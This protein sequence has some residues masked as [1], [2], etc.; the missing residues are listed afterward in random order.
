MV[1]V[2]WAGYIGTLRTYFTNKNKNLGCGR[3][4]LYR[5]IQGKVSK[6]IKK[7][8][9]VILGAIC[10][11]TSLGR[12]AGKRNADHASPAH[13]ERYGRSWIGR[14]RLTFQF[15]QN[16]YYTYFPFF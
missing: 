5:K 12:G 9:C 6:I 13:W 3:S 16:T 2:Q 14:L 15:T 1:T 10:A 7:K 8:N 4:S 11:T